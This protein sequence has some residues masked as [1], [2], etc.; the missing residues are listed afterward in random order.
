MRPALLEMRRFVRL[1]E[2]IGVTEML[3][4]TLVETF[5]I[6][7]CDGNDI[8]I[9]KFEMAEHFYD[10]DSQHIKRTYIEDKYMTEDGVQPDSTDGFAFSIKGKLYQRC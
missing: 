2:K 6:R 8:L 1:T 4:K 9:A 3:I 7:S 10:S 5:T